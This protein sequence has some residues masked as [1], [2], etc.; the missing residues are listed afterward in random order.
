M[1]IQIQLTKKPDQNVY[2]QFLP[3]SNYLQKVTLSLYQVVRIT[4]FDCSPA[5]SVPTVHL[6]SE[7]QLAAKKMRINVALRMFCFQFGKIWQQQPET[8]SSRAQTPGDTAQHTLGCPRTER[9]TR[10]PGQR[11]GAN[12]TAPLQRPLRWPRACPLVATGCPEHPAPEP[13]PANTFTAPAPLQVTP[14]LFE[15]KSHLVTQVSLLIRK[16]ETI[17]THQR[18][19]KQYSYQLRNCNYQRHLKVQD[20]RFM[21]LCLRSR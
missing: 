7:E 9:S 4:T 12:P 3:P 19:S 17:L 18:K 13:G 15:S 5:L 21:I 10:G 6:S 20:T 11:S 8:A 16:R 2:Q 1:N 14:Q